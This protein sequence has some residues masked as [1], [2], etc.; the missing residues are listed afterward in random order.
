MR[1]EII[2]CLFVAM[3]FVACGSKSGGAGGDK[4]GGAGDSVK[5]AACGRG[6]CFTDSRDGQIYRTVKMGTAVWMAENLNYKADSSLCHEDYAPNCQT[7]GRLYRWE[8]AIKACPQ[9]WRLPDTEEWIDLIE[10]AGGYTLAGQKLKAEEG[11]DYNKWG[12]SGNGYDVFGFS[13]LPGSD[14]ECFRGDASRFGA[15]G[16]SGYWWSAVGDGDDKAFYLSL[17]HHDDSAYMSYNETCYYLSVRCVSD[18]AEKSEDGE[19]AALSKN[20]FTDPRDGKAYKTVN[21]GKQTWMAENLSYNADSSL[22]YGNNESNCKKYGRLYKWETAV[23][24]CPTG[25]HLSSREEWNSLV[26][27]AGGSEVAGKK[28]KS[29]RGWVTGWDYDREGERKG[30]DDYGTSAHYESKEIALF[31][32]TMSEG[33][34]ITKKVAT[35]GISFDC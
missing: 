25:W 9:G 33:G 4:S 32:S 26:Q 1:I 20:T 12:G 13:A 6:D 17:G 21:I 2:S 8:A 7:Y 29:K 14:R 15:I 5:A 16:R 27:R 19:D 30:T 10:A 35:L 22:C 28:L 34:E 24:V 11:W 3:L 31:L 18:N 23:R